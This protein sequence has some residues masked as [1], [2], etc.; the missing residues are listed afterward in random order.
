MKK[1]I[2]IFTILLLSVWGIRVHQVNESFVKPETVICSSLESMQY[3]DLDITIS[4]MKLV[5]ESALKIENCETSCLGEIYALVYVDI[6]NKSETN[7]KLDLTS[8]VLQSGAY[9]NMIV[10]DVFQNI[11]EKQHSISTLN[12]NIESGQTGS[13]ILVYLIPSYQFTERQWKMVRYRNYQMIISLYPI[14]RIIEITE[15]L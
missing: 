4:G 1:Y 3:K 10:M 2:G 8:F 13:V 12:P 15:I 14:K 6:A 7:Q 5:S 9:K 11:N